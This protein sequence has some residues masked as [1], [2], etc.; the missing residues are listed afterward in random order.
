MIKIRKMSKK[1]FV[2]FGITL[3][4][5]SFA[6]AQI[7]I[8]NDDP[9]A[10][11]DVKALNQATYSGATPEGIIAP[12]L[13]R[14]NLNNA[15][16]N[17]KYGSDQNGAIVYVTTLN[18]TASGQGSDITATGYYYFDSDQNKWVAMKYIPSVSVTGE[19]T[20]ASNGLTLST[21]DVQLGGAL[22]KDTSITGTN[23]LTLGTPLQYNNSAASPGAGKILKS[24]ASGNA[25]WTDPA[26]LGLTAEPWYNSADGTPATA[27]N[28][29]IY[30]TGKVGIGMTYDTPLGASTQLEVD[31]AATNLNSL[32]VTTS[33][34][35]F[36]AGNLAHS[37]TPAA[38][39]TITGVKDGGTYTLATE[40]ISSTTAS[41]GTTA[42]SGGA[43]PFTP[44]TIKIVDSTEIMKVN[45]DST[46]G[47]SGTYRSGN[48]LYTMV[49]I[50]NYLYIYVSLFL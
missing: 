16:T 29:N 23:T 40:Y 10:T 31:G 36:K 39:Y 44:K 48:R 42:N 24:D 5:G 14:L 28:Q 20:T 41:F 13:T 38:T 18:G 4:F 8:N 3:L 46:I 9:K 12:R 30:V 7:G 43:S 21:Y 2:L 6:N 37:D 34:V 50:G 1:V 26:D 49:C 47:G 22:T 33:A 11:L 17:N 19:T 32:P 25:T 35:D 27:K 45:T 15:E